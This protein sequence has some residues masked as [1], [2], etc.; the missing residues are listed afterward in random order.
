M[1]D[2]PLAFSYVRMSTPAQA[3]GDSL[4]RQTEAALSYAEA[5]DLELASD[6]QLRDIGLSAYRGANAVE[7]ALA[8]FLAAVRKGLIAPGS[9]LI[10]E[11]LD[12]ISRQ[13]LVPA[14]GLFTE[15]LLGGITIV[16]LSDNKVYR[17]DGGDLAMLMYSLMVMSRAHEESEIKSQ[18][19]SAVWERKRRDAGSQ[20]MTARCPTW[21][22][23]TETG[24][25]EVIEDRAQVVRTIF[26]DGLAGIGCY[27]IAKRLNQAKVRTFG[28]AQS[29]GSSSVKKVL[30]GRT[31]IGELQSH[32]VVRGKR[33]PEGKPVQGYY[34]AIIPE[35]EF[36]R[37]Q[38]LRTQRRSNAGGR[39]GPS[40]AN[41][42]SGIARCGYCESPMHFINKGSGSRGGTYLVCS[43]AQKGICRHR[44][45]WRYSD[46][47]I[48]FLRFV[49]EIE[50]RSVIR[51]QSGLTR[52]GELRTK[53]QEL[54][55]RAEDE[56]AKRQ[57]LFQLIYDNGVDPAVVAG[58][59]TSVHSRIERTSSALEQAEQELAEAQAGELEAEK[60]SAELPDLIREAQE[61]RTDPYLVRSTLVAAVRSV[62]RSI[63][64][65]TS[66]SAPSAAKARHLAR[67]QMQS[68]E[69]MDFLGQLEELW[70]HP[71]VND[72]KFVVE[73]QSGEYRHVYP[74]PA[75]PLVVRQNTKWG[76]LGLANSTAIGN[77]SERDS[78]G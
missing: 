64:V 37:V 56:I 26:K 73:F 71:T 62:I 12:R 11:S 23:L 40:V 50:L 39:K 60:V 10:V 22:R 59:L 78:L 61:P 14:M 32:R 51:P 1:P 28:R 33:I 9:F 34:P 55:G 31:V 67:S 8:K 57:K 6:R 17:T 42:F 15:I 65:F 53:I 70:A 18:R 24:Q 38:A 63:H 74:D 58:E 13:Q 48:S 46:F 3:A 16:T 36:H 75:D 44:R 68:T 76:T 49:C 30:T 2:R 66:G 20:P 29:W 72:P 77:A 7:G 47:E 52:A 41:L 4:R 5:H 25:F 21:L 69:D 27:S 43:A 19:I 45:Y 54:S 35:G